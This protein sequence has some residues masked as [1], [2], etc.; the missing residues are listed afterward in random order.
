MALSDQ[1]KKWTGVSV[2]NDELLQLQAENKLNWNGV[3]AVVNRAHE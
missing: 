3:V 1:V 2:S